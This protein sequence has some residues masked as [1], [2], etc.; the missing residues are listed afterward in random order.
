MGLDL[1]C[2]R[3]EE[4]VSEAGVMESQWCYQEEKEEILAA[5]LLWM[6]VDFAKSNCLPHKKSSFELAKKLMTMFLQQQMFAESKGK[7]AL[8]LFGTDGIESIL[9]CKD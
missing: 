8:F 4:G 5:V 6:D 7:I 3:V 2:A 1:A 9:A